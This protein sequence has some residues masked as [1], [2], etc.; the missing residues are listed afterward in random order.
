MASFVTPSFPTEHQGVGRMEA[1][2]DHARHLGRSLSGG[3][4]LAS[5]LLAAMA[6]AVLV[7]AY[8]VMDSV[9]EGQ[10][11][12]IWIG[13]WLSAFAALAVLPST[14]R[15]LATGLKSRMDAGSQRVAESRAERCLWALA[16]TDPRVMSE[17]QA[18]LQRDH[19][20]P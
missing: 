10:L 17:L 12:V 19:G 8:Q 16:Q 7:A 4:A 6:A 3:R 20:Q 11:L 13:A 1:V 5:V 9:A 2:A 14:A 18:V 15:K